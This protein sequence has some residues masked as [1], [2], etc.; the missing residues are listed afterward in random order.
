MCLRR[1]TTELAHLR[2]R[3]AHTASLL[4]SETPSD[5]FR[6]LPARPIVNRIAPSMILLSMPSVLVW[7]ACACIGVVTGGPANPHKA[8][9]RDAGNLS[10][11]SSAIVD[12][13]VDGAGGRD[14]VTDDGL[15]TAI[16]AAGIGT[17]GAPSDAGAAARSDVGAGAH[18]GGGATGGAGAGGS[19]GG[20]SDDGRP[21]GDPTGTAAA[22]ATDFLNS[23]GVC[24]HIGQGVDRAAESATAMSYA[25]IYNLRDDGSPGAVDG[26]IS[27]RKSGIRVTLLSNA[28]IPSTI[29][30]AKQLRAADALL[31]I[32]G[33]NE[34]NNFQVTYQNQTSSSTTTFLPV[35]KF[36][37][38]LYAAV[39][40]EPS[41][42]GIPVF[43]SSEAGGSEPDNVGLQ[44]LTIPSGLNIAMP[45]GTRYADYANTHN[46]VCGHKANLVDNVAWNAADAML[47]G[48]WDGL[49]V[50]YGRTWNRGFT[51]IPNDQ[52]P[53]L[54]RVTTETGWATSGTGSITQEQ[55]GRLF[56]NLYL[57]AFKQG[58]AYTFIYM[59]RD[60]PGQGDWGLFDRSYNPKISGTYLHNLTTILAD[61]GARK[62]P[63]KLNYA[64]DPLPATVHDLLFQKSTGTFSLVIWDERPSGGTHNV[65]IQLGP[66]RA[67]VKIYDPTTGIAPT[68]TLRDVSS[69][70]LTLSDHPIVLEL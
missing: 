43:H 59:L 69:V 67:L 28:G 48:D 34:P 27:M 23:L 17:A 66:S 16:G 8:S 62:A 18:S 50:E 44:F 19:G 32:E 46:Y 1:G 42:S 63:G 22:K 9:V 55:Q 21:I 25:G 68:Q 31:A 45:S 4:S 29:D 11:D 57:A 41:L 14:V 61:R 65:T 39:K 60:D 2:V 5:S 51:G 49:Y 47:N 33:P 15:I 30:M 54:P 35:A 70:P 64:I 13:H 40:A 58:I 52:L 37:R 53:T 10:A 26:W 38:D 56:M 3:L 6:R 20:T 36:Q 7:G 12:R 24:T